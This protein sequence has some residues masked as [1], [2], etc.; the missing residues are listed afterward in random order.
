MVSCCG[1]QDHVTIGWETCQCQ[2][3]VCQGNCIWDFLLRRVIL[4][5]RRGRRIPIPRPPGEILRR[6]S[7][8][9]SFAPQ[10]DSKGWGWAHTR[11]PYRFAP[12]SGSRPWSEGLV[13]QPH[14]RHS[15]E[16]SD[17]ESTFCTLLAL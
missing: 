8:F 17:E 15:E 4:S 11:L 3:S 10:N 12:S 16:R 5:A 13:L 6:F 14:L 1:L 9:A 2:V 7:R